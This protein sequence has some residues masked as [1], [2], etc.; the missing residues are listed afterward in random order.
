MV[1]GTVRPP[2]KGAV[3]LP[4]SGRRAGGW[5][6]KPENRTPRRC[7]PPPLSG[8][9][10]TG[11]ARIRMAVAHAG[12]D[13]ACRVHALPGRGDAHRELLLDRH[14]GAP[15]ALRR[16]GQLRRARRGP[17]L[18]AGAR[19]QLLVRRRHHPDGDRARHADGAVGEPQAAGARAG[20]HGVL[21]AH[22]A[23]DD[24]GGEPVAVFLYAADRP[25]R[26]AGRPVRRRQP[27]LARRSRPG[28][29]RDD[30]DGGLEG[31]RVLHDLLPRRAA[32]AAAGAR[33]G[34][35][36]RGRLALVLLPPRDLPAAH[37]DDAV[38]A[39]ERDHQLVQAGRPPL[40][41][42][43]GRA[44]TTPRAC[45]STTSTRWRS[46]SSTPPTPRR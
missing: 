43:Q 21:R 40:H 18:L 23:A 39:G 37:A 14:G 45:S 38:R 10:R 12:R 4:R 31:G 27:Q 15:V 46:A 25:A 17:D 7:A 1:H 13:P 22:G 42:H 34:G 2:D 20:A 30:A 11:E 44:R 3:S 16:P 41:P 29:S 33:G 32:V 35:P 6:W 5:F 28:P 9:R 8:G 19:Q 24:R 36:H 26:Q